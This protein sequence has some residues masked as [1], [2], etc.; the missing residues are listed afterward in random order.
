MTGTAAG[1]RLGIYRIPVTWPALPESILYTRALRDAPP[2]EGWPVP[3]SRPDTG[4]GKEGKGPPRSLQQACN[5]P[6]TTFQPWPY[7]GATKAL[8]WIYERVVPAIRPWRR[9]P[10]IY[11]CQ[12]QP[13][14]RAN[15]S[16]E[17]RVGKECRSRWSP[18]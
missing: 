1:R 9:R 2:L 6:A 7:S 13:P 18:Y 16:E 4:R 8:L 3:A 10:G 11:P 14:G 15:R 17:R 12:R 5:M